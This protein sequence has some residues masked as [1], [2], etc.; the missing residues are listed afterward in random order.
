M[1]KRTSNKPSPT[2]TE[3]THIRIQTSANR[4]GTR[5]YTIFLK[6]EHFQGNVLKAAV[7]FC[8][9]DTVARVW[10]NKEFREYEQ[11]RI[12]QVFHDF[13]LW[14]RLSDP[15]HKL[16]NYSGRTKT[17][18]THP[19]RKDIPKGRRPRVKIDDKG[20]DDADDQPPLES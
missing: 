11:E 8:R 6:G 17:G 5:Q 18:R 12:D 9:R 20:I 10:L 2:I 14:K 19:W 1:S 4:A 13:Y 3:L 7:V 16:P 15:H